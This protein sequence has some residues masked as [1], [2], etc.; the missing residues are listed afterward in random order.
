MIPTREQAY[1]ALPAV[2][3]LVGGKRIG[4]SE[5]STFEKLEPATGR[6]IAHV[7]N[8]TAQDV[9]DAVA[10]ARAAFPEWRD[11][12]ADVRRG[13][14]QQVARLLREHDEEFS[15]IASVET[16]APYRLGTGWLAADF[17]DYYAG[18]VDKQ[19]G[20]LVPTYPHKGLDYV[21][22]EPYG[23]VAA[24]LSWNGPTGA[25][26]LKTAAALGGRELRRDE[27]L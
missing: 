9:Q 6:V 8:A 26:G 1:E 23:V 11:C 22:Y 27:A 3:M 2:E 12:R 18:W 19:E 16:G 4:S 14:L 25:C 24:L 13:I 17:F 15:L 10:G 20:L 5:R 21:R 7:P